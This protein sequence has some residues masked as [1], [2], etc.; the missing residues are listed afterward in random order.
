MQ[1]F[2]LK[3]GSICRD[4]LQPRFRTPF[5]PAQLFIDIAQDRSGVYSL[6]HCRTIILH[7]RSNTTVKYISTTAVSRG[8]FG[9]T[10][11]H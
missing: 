10:N 5:G 7:V 6:R 9:G 1:S 3:Y 8:L 4:N 2:S 11:L